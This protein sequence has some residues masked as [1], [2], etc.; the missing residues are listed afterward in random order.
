LRRSLTLLAACG[1]LT[2]T[3]GATWLAFRPL[4]AKSPA[5][6]GLVVDRDAHDFG[7]VGQ[8]ETHTATFTVTN[9]YPHAI[10][11]RDIVKG[12]SC[13]DAGVEPPVLEP[14]ESG[15][16]SVSWR[17]GGRRGRTSEAVT[18][19]AMLGGERPR[20]VSIPVRVTAEVK[21]DVEFAP[22]ELR[23]RVGHPGLAVLRCQPGR[24]GEVKLVMA[25][26]NAAVLGAQVDPGANT[27][28]VTYM[29]KGDPAELNDAVVMVKTTCATEE[30]VKV[31]VTRG[32]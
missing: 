13:A 16:L 21:P 32:E 26:S 27:V 14:G 22:E 19:V 11:V 24:G 4:P 6:V 20:L 31:P 29:P 3:V 15:K 8:R 5:V 25:Y 12:C 2:A 23:F 7:T 17:T 28:T 18:V 9:R 1:S 10:E 30:W